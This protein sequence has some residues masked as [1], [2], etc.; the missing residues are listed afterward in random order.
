MGYMDNN[1]HHKKIS[2]CLASHNGERY[3]QEQIESIL[4]QLSKDDE[5]IISND[6]VSDGTLD[7]LRSIND[8]RIKIYSYMHKK[9][10]K[11]KHSYV[12]RN[13]ENALIHSDGDYIFLSDQDDWWMPNKIAICLEALKKHSLVVHQAE[14]CDDRLNSLNRFMY[15]DTFTFKN[16]LSLKA[17]KYY[18]CT[19]AFR[20]ELLSHILPFPS[21]L[22]LHDQ[23]IGCLAEI[24]GS[25]YYEK[26]PLI[27]YRLHGDS[28][29]YGKSNNPIWFKI[30]YRIYMYM[31]LIFR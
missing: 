23:W 27:K 31:H 9:K 14:M 6:S 1:N 29:S 16:Y 4:C 20:R 19:L 24:K 15:K 8:S 26:A 2:V 28:V 25:V 10:S 3:I 18:G 12:C 21:K 30:W 22:I 13:F 7:I 5:I 17:G 11:Y